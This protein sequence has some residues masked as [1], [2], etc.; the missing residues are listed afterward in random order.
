MTLPK[1]ANAYSSTTRASCGARSDHPSPLLT[2]DQVLDPEPVVHT[3]EVGL[4][5]RKAQK[6]AG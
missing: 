2:L 1:V 4:G 5:G 6:T 3:A